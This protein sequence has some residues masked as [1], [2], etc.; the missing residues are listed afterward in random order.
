MTDDKKVIVGMYEVENPDYPQVKVGKYT[1]C[2]QGG[3]S[4]WMQTE[5]GEG[6]EFQDELF[7]K[8]LDDFWKDHF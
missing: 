1:I 7:E 5:K 6:A 8:V 3:N 2:R 4:V